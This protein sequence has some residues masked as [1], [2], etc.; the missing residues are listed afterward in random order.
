MGLRHATER[1]GMASLPRL[2]IVTGKGGV[3]KTTIAAALALAEARRGRRV[4]LAE[5]NSRDRAALLLGVEATGSKL[6]AV[7]P[8][9]SLVD[10]NPRDTLR[11]YVLLTFKFETVYKAVFEN[12]LVKHFLRLVPSLAELTMLGKIWF[13]ERELYDDVPRFDVIVLDAPAT[14]HA[15]AMLRAPSVVQSTVPAGPLRENARAMDQLLRDNDR[16]VVHVVTT[17][18]EMPVNEAV[19]I[20]RAAGDELGMRMGAT[21]INQRLSP[22]SPEVILT[23]D[24]SAA[25]DT[26]LREVVRVL[27]AREERRRAG[28]QYLQRLPHLMLRNAVSIPRLATDEFGRAALETI[29]TSIAPALAHE[30]SEA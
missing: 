30:A 10:M 12:R 2:R 8:G 3:G 24:A 5:V 16:C 9:I 15:V 7:L 27:R 23:L 26:R 13:H 20:E 17:P 28:E 21:F 14:G 22:V 4:L 1:G 6:T 29:A 19:E 11:E 18:E 25:K